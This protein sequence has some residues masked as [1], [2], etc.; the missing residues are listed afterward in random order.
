VP[1][2]WVTLGP[3]SG[4]EQAA[5][6]KSPAQTR[7][8]DAQGTARFAGMSPGANLAINPSEPEGATPVE[9]SDWGEHVSVVLTVQAGASI[10][11]TVRDPEKQPRD[12]MIVIAEPAGSA[13]GEP[14]VDGRNQGSGRYVIG[15]LA[16]GDYAVRVSD[17]MNPALVVQGSGAGGLVHVPPSETTSLEVVYGGFAGKVSGRVSDREGNPIR[18]AWVALH[19]QA[20]SIGRFEFPVGQGDQRRL[21]DG[22]GHFEIDGLRQGATFTLTATHDYGGYAQLASVAVGQ[23]VAVTLSGSGSLE[24]T[25]VGKS[26]APPSDFELI[27]RHLPSGMKSR[28][29]FGPE[30]QGKWSMQDVSAGDV[31]VIAST[32]SELAKTN[33]ALAAGQS[34]GGVRLQLGPPPDAA[35]YAA[36]IRAATPAG[37]D[38]Q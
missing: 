5:Q 19:A 16:G 35:E 30:A 15:P 24:G 11:L 10:E 12:R 2:T 22:E 33:V 38:Q 29:F 1:N 36:S 32:R 27:V 14:P 28:A 9:V 13:Q 3:Q 20:D 25:V 18:D 23:E 17:G 7:S 8:T 6:G 31:E 37:H 4:T 21:T 26:G 34:L